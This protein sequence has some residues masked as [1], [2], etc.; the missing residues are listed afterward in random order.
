MAAMRRA[1]VTLGG[2]RAVIDGNRVPIGVEGEA[3][4]RGDAKIASIAAAS[5]LAKCARDRFMIEA[6][7][8]YPEYGFERHFGY[9]TFEHLTAL[10]RYGPSPI[11]RL[12]FRPVRLAEQACLVFER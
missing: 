8:E 6:A 1:V 9:G 5:I 3:T 11:H 10:R 2:G 7:N 4:V 12:S